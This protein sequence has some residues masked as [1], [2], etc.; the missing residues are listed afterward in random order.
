MPQSCTG[1]PQL[2]SGR[3]SS[4]EMQHAAC[5]QAADDFGPVTRLQVQ[6]PNVVYQHEA[7]SRW[8][9]PLCMWLGMQ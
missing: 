4:L 8:P 6:Q 3:S 5:P 1:G 2:A 7:S 9:P